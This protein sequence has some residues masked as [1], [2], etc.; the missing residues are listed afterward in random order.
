MVEAGVRSQHVDMKG[1]ALPLLLAVFVAFL[2]SGCHEPYDY[3][4]HRHHGTHYGQGRDAYYKEY[5]K[6][7]HRH[8][9][10]HGHHSG[11]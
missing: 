10:H 3:Y 11:Y 4:G 8:P 9:K 7:P 2:L 6:M 1:L 5:N